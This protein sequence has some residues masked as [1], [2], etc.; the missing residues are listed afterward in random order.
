GFD[1]KDPYSLKR[2]TGDF[3]TILNKNIK[4]KI[5]GI[6]LDYYYDNVEKEVYNSIN[7]AIEKFEN[8]GAEIKYVNIKDTNKTLSAF[9]TTLSSEAYAGH[10]SRLIEFP[11]Q[12]DEEV[13]KRLLTGSH[14][15]LYNY[16]KAQQIKNIT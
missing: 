14:I 6:P 4:G 5:I 8:L 3:E 13:R 11:N 12:W 7:K 15:N 16:I 1:K 2:N 10:E 9:W